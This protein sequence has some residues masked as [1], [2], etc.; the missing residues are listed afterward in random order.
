MPT[1]QNTI[2]SIVIL[3]TAVLSTQAQAAKKKPRRK[4]KEN[5][6]FE[7]RFSDDLKQTP[8]SQARL[9]KWFRDAKFGAFIHFGAYS[10]L[11][12]QYKGRGANHRYSE[13]IQMSAKSVTLSSPQSTMTALHFSS[14]WS[15]RTTLLMPQSSNAI[16][17]RN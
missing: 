5:I 13:W 14:P 8:D 17:S 4:P 2:L 3:M 7:Y 16:S 11:A 10:P 1:R 15:A 9:D 6:T 12:G